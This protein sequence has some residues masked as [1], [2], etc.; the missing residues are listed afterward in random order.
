MQADGY[1][2]YIFASF[3]LG[4]VVAS[5][6][7]TAN[8]AKTARD[9]AVSFD[10]GD[11]TDCAYGYEVTI[12]AVN[13]PT[14]VKARTHIRFGGTLSSSN[15]P[16]REFSRA[17]FFPFSGDTFKVWTAPRL[18]DKL[19]AA[20]SSFA[21]DWLTYT[22][23]N[24][25]PAPVAC[26]GGHVAKRVDDG[27]TYATIQMIGTT[28]Y[29]VDPTSDPLNISHLWTLPSGVAFAS[30]SA[31]TDP[32]PVLEV[33]VGEYMITHTVTDDDNGK[34]RTQYVNV[35]VHDDSDPPH[36][37][38]VENLSGTPEDGWNWTIQVVEGDTDLDAIPDGC[39]AILWT[40]EY[41]GGTQQSVRGM[42]PGRE[43]IL[44]VG[45]VA[46][47]S[48][49]GSGED[50]STSIRFD[51]ISPLAR[52]KQITSY[53]KV[54]EENANPDSWSEILTLRVKRAVLQ[55][56]NYYSTLVEAGF[57]VVV[58]AAF[59]DRVY[60]QLFLQRAD[61]YAQSMELV[62][63]VDARM[64]CDRAGLFLIAPHPAYIHPDDRGA[65][66][67]VAD[68]DEN[69]VLSWDFT[70]EHFHKVESHKAS[71]FI[72]GSSPQPVFSIYP[73]FAPGEAVEAPT[74]ERL[75]VDDQSD[76]DDRTGM[77]GA[78]LDMVF[79]DDDDNEHK[80]FDLPVRLRGS[81]DVFD[82]YKEYTAFSIDGNLR[83]IDLSQYL[84]YPISITS[85]LEGGTASVD[86]VFRMATYARAGQSYFP[87]GD[88]GNGLPPIGDPDFGWGWNPVIRPP[89]GL[90]SGTLFM[91][92]TDGYLYITVNG[93]TASPVWTVYAVLL[94]S[95]T[96]A[97]TGTLLGGA[98]DAFSSRYI[99]GGSTV[100][101]YLWTTTQFCKIEDSFNATGS[102]ECVNVQ[103]F[104]DTSI[105]R[106]GNFER[107]V[108]GWGIIVSDYGADGV[109]AWYTTD[110]GATDNE[111]QITAHYD[112]ALNGWSG[113]IW[114][115]PHTPGRAI[116]SAFTGTGSGS[117]HPG[118]GFI[119]TD[120]GATWTQLTTP[121]IEPNQALASS[122][123][124]PF[125]VPTT[126]YFA[127]STLSGFNY[128]LRLYRAVGSSSAADV[129][130]TYSASS[131]GPRGQG[132]REIAIADDDALSVVMIGRTTT[133]SASTG[134]FI[135]RN[136]AASWTPLV[137][138]GSNP[139]VTLY[140]G[141][142]RAIYLLGTNGSFA[143]S[144]G[145]TVEDRT[146]DISTSGTNVVLWGA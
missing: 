107:S 8:A 39:L 143:F 32:S 92:N 72:A 28:S 54:M 113:G 83:G 105:F 29:V 84:F 123:V 23:Q 45:Y 18:H 71:G 88:E 75:I 64:T 62:Q 98:V 81:W 53:S 117:S 115:D 125:T 138:P 89:L 132:N 104:R 82:F 25:A 61:F 79:Y 109:W 57:D 118:H 63:A 50:G 73:G 6:E 76:L 124:A 135:T 49:K 36:E 77:H 38:V 93:T 95:V 131:Y 4:E 11:E 10:V 3:I 19:V 74:R 13:T 102:R 1:K 9:L 106:A 60:P 120:Y 126:F 110:G 5:G 42:T 12:H 86:A 136:G 67:Q 130:P 27:E 22:D 122:I 112:T 99:S 129:S 15:I 21:P 87:P 108:P 66:T 137:V 37:V 65:I 43:H 56:I 17:K 48:N 58:D 80:A 141:G 55:I 33:N 31:N 68:L 46:R 44:G 101:G 70:R 52:L 119:T 14:V 103:S 78:L 20:D 114:L 134:V 97:P 90:G 26:S 91:G 40:E 142:R 146:G 128:N 121:D 34:T 96:G 2:Q 69:D 59:L 111:V 94:S 144:D 51:V 41:L 100:D 7:I 16:V 139:Y 47:D 116:T 127:H 30:G 24:E 140:M 85:T 35:R 145:E 133:A